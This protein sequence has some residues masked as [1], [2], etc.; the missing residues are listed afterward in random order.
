MIIYIA[1]KITGNKDY[2]KQFNE[3]KELLTAQGHTAINPCETEGLKYKDYIDIGL[4]KLS[5]CE[6]AYFLKNWR[7]SQGAKL[8]HDYAQTVGLKIYYEG[9]DHDIKIH[10]TITAD[11]QKE[12]PA[13]ID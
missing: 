5:K 1:G 9:K 10:D 11:Q 8:E 12:Q 13:D 2:L 7:D 6:A 4:A 3:A